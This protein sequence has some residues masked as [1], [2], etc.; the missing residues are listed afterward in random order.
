MYRDIVDWATP[1][2][3]GPYILDDV[4]PQVSARNDQRF[5]QGQF[6][7]AS[8]SFIPRLFVQS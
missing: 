5:S 7:R 3:P 4:L 1:K 6:A 2:M 8:F